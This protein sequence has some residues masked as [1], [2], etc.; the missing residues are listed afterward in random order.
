[1]GFVL[2]GFK[3]FGCVSERWSNEKSMDEIEVA[4]LDFNL[5]EIVFS[6]LDLALPKSSVLRS[7]C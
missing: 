1:M 7:R 6:E 5:N 3:V 2:M 4:R